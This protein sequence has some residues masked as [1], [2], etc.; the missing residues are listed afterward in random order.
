MATPQNPHTLQYTTS[1]SSVRTRQSERTEINY[2]DGTVSFSSA[3]KVSRLV[4][5]ISKSCIQQEWR[6]VHFRC[7]LL[8]LLLNVLGRSIQ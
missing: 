7:I 3:K 6:R 8:Q 2:D 5:V 4:N 1:G